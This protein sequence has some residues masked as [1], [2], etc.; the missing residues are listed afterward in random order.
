MIP[1]VTGILQDMNSFKDSFNAAAERL[2]K[3]FKISLCSQGKE[4]DV[5][6]E[7]KVRA[8][9]H[10]NETFPLHYVLA[11]EQCTFSNL[12]AILDK[13][14]QKPFWI[15]ISGL[16]YESVVTNVVALWNEYGFTEAVFDVDKLGRHSLSFAR[17]RNIGSNVYTNVALQPDK[18]YSVFQRAFIDQV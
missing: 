11:D 9:N 13:V 2:T 3:L 8:I 4:K 15:M 16:T 12:D 5:I 7:Q 14:I 17:R 18:T 6:I 1:F 10:I